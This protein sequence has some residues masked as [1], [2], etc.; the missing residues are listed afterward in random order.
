MP[1]HDS[2]LQ[3][4]SRARL[5]APLAAVARPLLAAVAR[6]LLAVVAR[7]LLVAFAC[8]LLVGLAAAGCGPGFTVTTPAGFA[9]LEDQD[10]Y[11]YRATTAEGVV[12]AVRREDNVPYGDLSFWSSAVDAHLRRDG[13]TAKKGLDVQTADGVQGRQIRYGRHR[14]GREHA[15]WASVFVTEDDVVVVEVGG[16]QT[17]FQKLEGAVNSAIQSLRID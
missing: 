4:V 14:N 15:F 9:E 17:Y 6:P 11:G 8:P 16:D 3:H 5:H 7:P 10:E 13:Y 1:A 2:D 12:V